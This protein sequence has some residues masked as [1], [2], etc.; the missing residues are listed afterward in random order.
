MS[1]RKHEGK[2]YVCLVRCSTHEQTETSIADQLALLHAFARQHGMIHAGGDVELDGVSG[3]HPGA[4]TDIEQVTQRKRTAN[5]FDVL[6][7]Q[8]MSRLTRGGV[9]HGAKLEFDVAAVGVELIFAGSSVPEGDHAGIVKSVEYFAAKQ[10]AKS[11]SYSTARGQMSAL[12]QGRML[13]SLRSPYAVDRLYLS[14]DGRP[15]HVIR[16][17]PDRRRQQKL[18]PQ[19]RQV[20]ETYPAPQKG[21]KPIRY[22]KQA[23]ETA[24]F[25]PGA[26]DQVAAVRQ[27]F[28][29]KLIDGWGFWRI[30]KELN[31]AGVPSS[32][33]KRWSTMAVKVVLRNPV[34]VGVGIANRKTSALY[35]ERS[36]DAPR[37]ARLDRK[38][39]AARKRPRVRHRPKDE[40]VERR[41]PELEN[42]LGPDLRPSAVEYQARF[43]SGAAP[44]PCVNLDRHIDSPFIL[45]GL[46]RSKQGNYPMSG[47][48]KGRPSSPRRYY[49]VSKAYILPSSDRIGRRLVPAD[50][51][52]TAVLAAVREALMQSSDL[53]AQVEATIRAEMAAVERDEGELARL[54][55]E[56]E[57]VGRQIAFVVEELGTLGREAAKAKVRELESKL[58]ALADRITKA[59]LSAAGATVDVP[60]AVER[61]MATL[62][63]MGH[64]MNGLPMR[65][66]RSLMSVLISRLEIDLETMAF[67]LE[68]ALPDWAAF[69]AQSFETR[70]GLE[71]NFSRETVGKAHRGFAIPIA[72]FDCGRPGRGCFDCRRKAA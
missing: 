60:A 15:L 22:R 36:V 38:D 47:R 32:T 19:T 48:G 49:A 31:D 58:A 16:T 57:Q 33:G 18:D 54:H 51:I 68:L 67:D 37:P 27:I 4:R 10:Y 39:W 6:L 45:K 28:R 59:E 13:H 69:D 30:A 50:A 43:L 61:V 42:F 62:A 9:E 25:I 41:H 64:R 3:S 66:L 23:G 70:M 71:K 53:R 40:W 17:L 52:E 12:L 1:G 8:D 63:D 44:L 72:T 5:D 14:L 56:R 55:A 7:V 34:Y 35:N 26:D 29:R 24:I 20:I 2:R 46:L 65:A 11:V 21:M